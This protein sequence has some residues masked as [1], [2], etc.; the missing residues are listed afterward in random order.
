[1]GDVH[2]NESISLQLEG[3]A[4]KLMAAK[5]R[6]RAIFEAV[7]SFFWKSRV[8]NVLDVLEA[9]IESHL[10]IVSAI[11]HVQHTAAQRQWPLDVAVLQD[12]REVSKLIQSLTTHLSENR[13]SKSLE[14]NALFDLLQS[15]QKRILR[16]KKV[17]KP[18]REHAAQLALPRSSLDVQAV[19]EFALSLKVFTRRFDETLFSPL[20]IDDWRA[21]R[22][23]WIERERALRHCWLKIAQCDASKGVERALRTKA[24]TFK[25]EVKHGPDILAHATFLLELANTNVNKTIAA[26]L[27]DVPVQ[28]NERFDVFEFL[29]LRERDVQVAPSIPNPR[30]ALFQLA[31]ELS[32]LPFEK[33]RHEGGWGRLMSLAEKADQCLPREKE[34][35]VEYLYSNR[36]PMPLAYRSMSPLDRSLSKQKVSMPVVRPKTNSLVVALAQRS[37]QF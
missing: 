10:E 18:E 19:H 6:Y 5:L 25:N 26:R 34:A 8:A 16:E 7:E 32:G 2:S 24:R 35:L 33:P 27:L 15:L 4:E 3:R 14:G 11:E 31:D 22:E 13:E 1:V 17:A 21:C 12:V 37:K 9:V 28:S 30:R 23:K 29:L 20:T 36:G